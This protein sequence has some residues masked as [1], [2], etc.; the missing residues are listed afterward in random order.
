MAPAHACLLL[1]DLQPPSL[2]RSIRLLNP[3]L[4]TIACVC[5]ALI[6]LRVPYAVYLESVGVLHYL[7]GTAVV[8]LAIPLHQNLKRLLGDLLPIT[9]ALVAGSITSLVCG[10]FIARALGA[11]TSTMLSL[12][13]KSATA[14]VSMQIAEG[15]GGVP[16]IAACLTI[17][18]GIIGAVLGPYILTWTGVRSPRARQVCAR[19]CKSWHRNSARFRRKRNDGVRGKPSHGLERPPDCRTGAAHPLGDADYPEVAIGAP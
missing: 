5:G 12:A 7:L 13:P 3:T 2:G 17:F 15:I 9:L 16:A 8:A 10:L 4:L 14:A 19:Y 1:R 11:S 6:V 18:T